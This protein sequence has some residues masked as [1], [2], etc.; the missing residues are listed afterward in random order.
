MRSCTARNFWHAHEVETARL[1]K[2]ESHNSSGLTEFTEKKKL[3][4]RLPPYSSIKYQTFIV[5][6]ITRDPKYIWE[7]VGFHFV[8]VAFSSIIIQILLCYKSKAAVQERHLQLS[9][10]S[11]YMFFSVK[12]KIVCKWHLCSQQC[13]YHG[14]NT[15][16]RREQ[17]FS[18]F[19]YK[20][21]F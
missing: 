20:L 14:K 2:S 3:T 15:L 7:I 12:K 9:I 19:F 10:Y 5:F 11:S 6:G 4:S 8:I 16:S 18:G 21:R 17:H 1:S 13:L